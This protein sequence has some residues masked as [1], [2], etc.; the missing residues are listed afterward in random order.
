MQIDQL[1]AAQRAFFHTGKTRSA[2][3][4]RQA[5][6]KLRQAITTRE[7]DICAALQADL[8]KSPFESYMCEIGLVLSELDYMEKRLE[9]WMRPRRVKTPMSQFPSK[10]FVIPEPLG[11]AL[12]MSPWNY[13]FMLSLDPLV[14]A[15]AAGNCA[16]LKPSAYAPATS[17]IL[18]ELLESCFAPEYIAVVEGGR[19]ENTALLEQHFD[20]IFFTG[21]VAVGK[22]VMEKAAHHLTPVTL[23]LGGKSPCIID[24]SANLPLTAKRLAFGKYLNAGQTCVA[25]DYVLVQE[26]IRDELVTY[27]QREIQAF[28]GADPLACRDYVRIVNE[29][30]YHRLMGLMDSGHIVCGGIGNEQ[31]LQIAPTIL[32]DVSPDSPVMGEEIF[33]PILP[34]MTYRTLDEAI[35]FVNARPKP[36][37]LYLFTT[38]SQTECRVLH[39]CSFGGGCVNDTIIHLATSEMGFGGVGESGMGSYHGK[40]SFDTFTHYKSIVKKSNRIDMPI[41]YQPY[42]EKKERMLRRVLK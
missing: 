12:V 9:R 6:A 26:E 13:P 36:L 29:R 19:A 20:Y 4:R 10:S 39:E 16:V 3:Y 34:V 27:L 37:A 21:S 23:E 11:V 35:A 30:H 8:N 5:L 38:D 31:T 41:R 1:A 40:L 28:F 2:A 24:K 15:I 18:K 42:T 17:R 22:L 33:G 25:P 7:K 14:G 32:T